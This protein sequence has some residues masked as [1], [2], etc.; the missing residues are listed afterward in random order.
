MFPVKSIN[1]SLREEN[2][3]VVDHK[4]GVVKIDVFSLDLVKV[5]ADMANRSNELDPN[6]IMVTVSSWDE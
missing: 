5:Q 3:I 1:D 4:E 6:S 2:C